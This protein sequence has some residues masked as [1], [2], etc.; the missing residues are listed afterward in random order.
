MIPG[1]ENLRAGRQ[2]AMG[3]MRPELDE[4]IAADEESRSRVSFTEKLKTRSVE[5]ARTARR[6]ALHQQ[7]IAAEATLD[8]EIALQRAE[9]ESIVGGKQ[10]EAER[11]RRRVAEEGQRILEQAAKVYAGIVRGEEVE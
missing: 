6:E 10:I 4:I 11:Y 7:R 1:A 3:V 8:D 2:T 9:G 5:S